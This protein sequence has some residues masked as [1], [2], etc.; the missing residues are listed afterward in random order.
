MLVAE[1]SMLIFQSIACSVIN[2][3]PQTIA[4]SS[5]QLPSLNSDMEMHTRQPGVSST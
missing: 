5:S 4:L 1:W 2:V 3:D